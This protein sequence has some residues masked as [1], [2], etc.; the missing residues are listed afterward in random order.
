[1]ITAPRIER[2]LRELDPE[3]ADRALLGL[4]VAPAE[5][6]RLRVIHQYGGPPPVIRWALSEEEF[7]HRTAIDPHELAVELPSSVRLGVETDAAP[8]IVRRLLDVPSVASAFV[9]I[10]RPVG[11]LR[12]RRWHWPL[13][14]GLLGF[15]AS[16]ASA[17]L[18]RVGEHRSYLPA[19]LDVHRIEDDPSAVDLAVVAG[20]IA[21]AVAR[22]ARLRIVANAVVVLD[23]P[24]E[25]APVVEAQ[26]AT[27]RAATGATASALVGPV[28]LAD[29]LADL[30]E[31]A[32]RAEPFDVA[33]TSAA[34]SDL[35]LFAEPDALARATV[36]E[37]AR[38]TALELERAGSSVAVTPAL[39]VA[40]RALASAAEGPFDEPATE[41]LRI[42][43]LTTRTVEPA[44]DE[45][46]QQRWCQARV[47]E[48][49]D[50]VVRAGLNVVRFFIGPHEE[51]ALST[52]APLDE[53]GLPW[54]EEDAEAFRLTV[55]FVPAVRDPVAQR[56]ELDLPRFGRSP[57]VRFTFDV[58]AGSEAALARVVVLFRNRVL[59]TAVMR[60]RVGAPAELTEVT[61]V[62]PTLAGLDERSAFDVALVANHTDGVPLLIRHSDD[63]TLASSA[64]GIPA[65]ARRLADGLAREADRRALTSDLRSPATVGRLR[66]LAVAGHDLFHRLEDDLG[67][68][69]AASRIQVVSA[70]GDWLLPIELMYERWAPER[71]AR[72]CE[73]YLADPQDCDGTCAP[74]E[75]RSVLCPNAFWGLGKTIERHRFDWRVD[76]GSNPRGGHLLLA[77]DRPRP[78]RRDLTIRRVRLGASERV[79]ADDVATTVRKI[80]RN[81][82]AVRSWADWTRQLKQADTEL[83]ILV[84]H[85]DVP[86]A[87]L[88][89]AR[90][91]LDRAF[92]EW[93]YV[94]GG[95]PVKPIVLLFG[96]RTSGTAGDPAGFASDFMRAGA[97]T[98]FHSC[99]D[100]RNVHATE[101]AQRLARELLKPSRSPRTLSDVLATFRRDA[102]HEGAIVALAI[103]AFGDAD[104]SV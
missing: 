32:A 19:M 66:A 3:V 53:H 33:L 98:A 27:A 20:P 17:V 47:G 82:R 78:G 60:G 8:A 96:C 15:P 14:V 44:L 84:P 39:D 5:L 25:R 4:G 13:R 59:Q 104:W 81:G 68:L 35:L 16:A 91:W 36:P 101:L 37:I 11:S 86:N 10:R 21:D 76:R 100:L 30:V 49:G 72:I 55:A 67:P 29:L 28:E 88:E 6:G 73:R 87:R 12:R 22:L 95:R 7:R 102:V 58:P 41:A 99:T 70:R 26:L 94:T 93:P 79:S 62:V 43:Q 52:P 97:A 89:I 48:G 57:D 42:A 61:G 65:V 85:A 63:L 9:S 74:I 56:A 90:G 83:L 31:A 23:R 71:G 80:G 18:E 92:I 2:W 24:L 51:G 54:A 34:G 77:P 64:V 45:L 75:D 103:S 46:D 38:Q 40:G 50:N 1:V 69:R